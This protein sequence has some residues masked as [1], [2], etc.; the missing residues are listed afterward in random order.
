MRLVVLFQN[1][2]GYHAARLR[3]V[4]DYCKQIEWTLTAVQVTDATR[5]HEWGDLESYITFDLKTLL[6]AH[7]EPLERKGVATS[8]GTRA[9]RSFLDEAKPDVVAIPGWGTAIARGAQKWSRRNKSLTILMSESKRDDDER[10]WLKERLKSHRYVR[11]FDAALVGGELH[12]DYLVELGFLPERIFLGYDVVDNEYFTA[13]AAL[14]RL[15]EAQVRRT[16][17]RLP[18]RPFFVAVTRFIERKNVVRLVEAYSSYRQ[19]VGEAKAWD[20]AICGSGEEEIRIRA[21]ISRF[22]IERF[23]HLPGFVAYRQIGDWYG[24]ASA[25]IHPALREQ[26]GLVVN[27]ACAAGLP[28]LCSR[29]VG[30]SHD[31]VKED[32]N[33]WLFDPRSAQDIAHA[34]LRMHRLDETGRAL[35]GT[36]SREIIA[37]LTPD[38]FARNLFKA[39]GAAK[40]TNGKLIRGSAKRYRAS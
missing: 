25:F 35:M 31:L 9:I 20:L 36:R 28:I 4:D 3:A 18:A 23:C 24:L 16:D 34:L 2:G 30:A 40:A 27:E 1:V 8:A 39:I 21:T 11:R 38:L 12:A 17:P 29:A 19:L 10:C 15:H 33:G 26:W 5:E 13:R 37:N 32:V 7:A 14:A 6:P 22:G